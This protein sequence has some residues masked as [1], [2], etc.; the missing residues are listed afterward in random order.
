MQACGHRGPGGPLPRRIRVTHISHSGGSGSERGEARLRVRCRVLARQGLKLTR[1]TDLENRETGFPSHLG[2]W[3]ERYTYCLGLCDHLENDKLMDH[4]SCCLGKGA[5]ETL[6]SEAC[7]LSCG[8]CD[9]LEVN[10]HDEVVVWGL[11][12]PTAT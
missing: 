4:A 9:L 2:L 3:S 10:L 7:H 6:I 1:G 11:Q 5:G 8:E 12:A